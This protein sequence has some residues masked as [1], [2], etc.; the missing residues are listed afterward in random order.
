MRVYEGKIFTDDYNR[1][2]RVLKELDSNLPNYFADG[3]D[4][5]YNFVLDQLGISRMGEYNLD[6]TLKDE[7]WEWLKKEAQEECKILEQEEWE[8]LESNEKIVDYQF[9]LE[10]LEEFQMIK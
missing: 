3:L 6:V 9:F 2:I 7:T 5:K 1:I 4:T 10:F 8:S